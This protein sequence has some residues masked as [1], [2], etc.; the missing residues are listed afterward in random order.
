ME[1]SQ[2]PEQAAEWAR[3]EEQRFECD[4]LPDIQDAFAN[5]PAVP[6]WYVRDVEESYRKGFSHAVL[7]LAELIRDL[8]RMG[9]IRPD[10]IANLVE[11]W[12]FNEVHKWRNSFDPY[13]ES[14]HSGHPHLNQPSWTELRSAVFKRDKWTCALC[15]RG[16]VKPHCDHIK[17]VAVGGLPVMDNLQTLCPECNLVKGAA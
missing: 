5:T 14:V 4:G 8:K 3:A 12:G 9:Y 7:Y 17:S 10:E 1:Y 2:T 16:V 11:A 15:K 13:Q 6:E